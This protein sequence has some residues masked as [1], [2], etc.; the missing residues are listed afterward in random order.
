M[1]GSMK[2][3]VAS[4]APRACSLDYR[5]G[6]GIVALQRATGLL[7][8]DLRELGLDDVV[9][10]ALGRAKRLLLGHQYLVDLLARPDAGEDGLDRPLANQLR[11]NV[12]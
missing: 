1:A 3:A 2:S 9:L 5:V 7:A 6:G 8:G 4:N 10:V 11:G 12:A